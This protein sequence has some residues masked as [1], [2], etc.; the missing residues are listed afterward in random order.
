MASIHYKIVQYLREKLAKDNHKL[1]NRIVGFTDEQCYHKL[2]YSFRGREAPEGLR[3]TYLGHEILR[4]YF[5]SYEV[6]MP[7]NYC[8]GF[9]DL[10]YLDNRANMPY[11][12]EHDGPGFETLKLV[13]FEAKLAILLKLAD[14]M[15]SNLRDMES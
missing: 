9:L 7:E 5:E 11:Y 4:C 10:L 8:L 3:L 1:A 12:I 2:F 13:V 15:I 14:G 6:P